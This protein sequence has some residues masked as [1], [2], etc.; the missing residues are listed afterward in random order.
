ML[1]SYSL[2]LWVAADAFVL[3]LSRLIVCSPPPLAI[4]G[5]VARAPP[6]SIAP[7][8]H[9]VIAFVRIAKLLG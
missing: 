5:A 6:N 7:A 2:M 8:A 4:A 3:K 1:W 9:F